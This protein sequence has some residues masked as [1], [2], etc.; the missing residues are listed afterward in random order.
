MTAG[1]TIKVNLVFKD[2]ILIEKLKLYKERR[3]ELDIIFSEQ[4][5]EGEG[6]TDIFV[7]P[8]EMI[9]E[10]PVDL[11]YGQ[12][13]ISVIA[14]GPGRYLRRA[15]LSGCMDYLKSP[16][17]SE[18]LECRVDRLIEK[19]RKLFSF[20]W[21][22][23]TLLEGRLHCTMAKLGLSVQER[24]ILKKLILNRNQPVSRDVLYYAMWGKPYIKKS[25]VVDMHISSIRRKLYSH[26][27]QS[28]AC[29]TSLK[30]I[31]YLIA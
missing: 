7:L 5:V 18:E 2:P 8:V 3:T 10:H 31:G 11:L 26:L 22:D 14:Y 12:R 1:K 17:D 30:G 20:P 24:I 6:K 25:R 16:W 19:R 23:F 27:P 29:I 21:G 9:L 28:K 15:F 13:G 4:P